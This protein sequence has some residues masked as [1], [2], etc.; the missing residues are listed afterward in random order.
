MRWLISSENI[1]VTLY[2]G[3]RNHGKNIGRGFFIS[4]KFEN[5]G[6]NEFFGFLIRGGSDRISH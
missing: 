4:E 2:S 5:K 1:R 6:G 3:Q